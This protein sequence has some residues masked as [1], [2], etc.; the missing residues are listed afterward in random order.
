MS[1]GYFGAKSIPGDGIEEHYGMERKD[2]NHS[3]SKDL[4]QCV[5]QGNTLC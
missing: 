3:T 5:G 1:C 4:P 2:V